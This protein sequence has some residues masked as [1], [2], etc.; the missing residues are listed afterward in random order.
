[1]RVGEGEG[2][3]DLAEQPR[4]ASVQLPRAAHFSQWRAG[5]REGPSADWK[6]SPPV[7][8]GPFASFALIHRRRFTIVL[9]EMRSPSARANHV[10]V[11]WY[12]NH[13]R[14]PSVPGTVFDLWRARL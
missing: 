11:V 2:E 1:M 5:D 6:P 10:I 3:P 4:L 12:V 13:A 7:G 8:L 14:K 9:F